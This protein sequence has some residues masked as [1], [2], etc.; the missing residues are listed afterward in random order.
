MEN[1]ISDHLASGESFFI[2]FGGRARVYKRENSEISCV[3]SNSKRWEYQIGF[4]HGSTGERIFLSS[5]PITEP[6]VEIK[7]RC[8][9][10]RTGLTIETENREYKWNKHGVL[11]REKYINEMRLSRLIKYLG[12]SKAIY[13]NN[14][15]Y[16]YDL[17][18][19]LAVDHEHDAYLPDL[20]V[21]FSKIYEIADGNLDLVDLDKG[22]F[23]YVDDNGKINLVKSATFHIF[24][25]DDGEFPDVSSHPYITF[26][27]ENT[28]RLREEAEALRLDF[29][30]YVPDL[31]FQ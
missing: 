3:F 31:N 23:F 22:I 29:R 17:K 25:Q 16:L 30:N 2:I 4:R 12:E 19:Y 6:I 1:A 21:Y 8:T 11:V 14:T 13:I 10:R 27:R 15:H 18:G 5:T 20:R 9:N 24:L 28:A 26:L 7:K